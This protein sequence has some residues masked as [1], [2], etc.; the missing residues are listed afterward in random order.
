MQMARNSLKFEVKPKLA[1]KADNFAGKSAELASK[2]GKITGE[3]PKSRKKRFVLYAFIR[4]QALSFLEAVCPRVSLFP[5]AGV[6][7][8][9]I[10]HPF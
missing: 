8:F 2:V 7:L 10:N 3:P 1:S 4:L 5:K 6:S 9:R